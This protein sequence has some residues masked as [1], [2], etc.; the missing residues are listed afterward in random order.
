VGRDTL[1]TPRCNAIIED[2]ANGTRNNLSRVIVVPK[3]RCCTHRATCSLGKLYLCTQHSKLAKEG[4][5]NEDGQVAPRG[6]L[7]A[8][9]DNPQRFP[10]GLYP[11]AKGLVLERLAK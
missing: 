6:D 2:Y 7:R 10:N 5:V 9:R 11:W 1:G 3:S 4:L 8:V